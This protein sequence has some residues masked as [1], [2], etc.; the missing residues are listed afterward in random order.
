MAIS[1]EFKQALRDG[2]LIMIRIMISDSLVVDP[3]FKECDKMLAL[4][5]PA[6][7]NLYDEH[8]GENLKYLTSDWNKDYMDKQMTEIVSNFSKERLELLKKIC[9][10]LYKDRIEKIKSERTEQSKK[11]KISTQKYI[12]GGIVLG[13]A[14]ATVFGIVTAEPLL[15]GLGITIMVV[16]GVIIAID[17]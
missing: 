11:E 5:E 6:L 4:A 8:N 12:G 7:C 1:N 9:K 2:D 17:K 13:G 14:A 3:T 15:V 10:Y 16:G